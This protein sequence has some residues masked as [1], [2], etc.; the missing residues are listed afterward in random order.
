MAKRRPSGD[1][2]IR[3]RDDGRWEGRIVVGHKNNGAPIYRYVLAK[4]QAEL[5]QKLHDKIEMYR[6]ADLCED[7]NMPLSEWLDKWLKE[8]I[9]CSV[10]PNTLSSY[11]M[12]IKNQVNP[13]L[14]NRP[15]SSLTTQEIQKF[16]NTIKKNGRV[17]PSKKYGKQLADSMVC[18]VHMMLHEA[19][20]MAVRQKL[21]VNN[22]TNGTTLPKNNYAPKQILNDEQLNKFMEIIKTD[23]KWYDFFYTEITTGLRKGEICGL[24]WEDFNEQTGTM[25]IRRSIGRDTNGKMFVGNTKTN[26]G[27]REIILPPSTA[28][29]LRKRRENV[30]SEWI[31]P[32]LK[33]SEKPINPDR[34]YKRLKILLKKAG[35]PSIRFHDL[36]HTFA[37]HA[38]AGGVDAKTLS[39]ILGHENASFTLDT[40]THVTTDMQKSAA[41]IVGVFMDEIIGGVENG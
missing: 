9:M 14:G 33:K 29:L 32:N 13:Y 16:Y 20:D 4:T 12:M 21:I 25:K 41:R 19:L 39:G 37:T 1:G 40:Y 2:M 34:A 18:K 23:E 28:D 10:K 22:P 5:I 17:N 27:S 36:R 15:L 8:Y 30:S 26:N 31:F 11:T 24:K 38:I 6:D 7:C 35:L 3:K